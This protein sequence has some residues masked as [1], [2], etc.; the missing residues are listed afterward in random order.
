MHGF[1]WFQVKAALSKAE[2]L[3]GSLRGRYRELVE[4]PREPGKSQQKSL[5]EGKKNKSD[6]Q[7]STKPKGA[8][9]VLSLP[10]TLY[11]RAYN[12]EN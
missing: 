3:S 4:G 2:E 6:S 9:K 1:M 12:T 5:I 8:H 7:H 10:L 11:L